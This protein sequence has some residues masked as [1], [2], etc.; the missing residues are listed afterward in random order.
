[1]KRLA[2]TA[3]AVTTTLTYEPTFFQL[4]TVTDPLNHHTTIVLNSAG[5][6]TSVTDPPTH[7]WQVSR[8][9]QVRHGQQAQST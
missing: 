4:A 8:R 2:G 9:R 1:L 6:V 5:M 7:Q 3:D